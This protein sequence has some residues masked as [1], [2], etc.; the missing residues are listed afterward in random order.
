MKG[1]TNGEGLATLDFEIPANAKL[2]DDGELTIKGEKNG[3]TREADEDLDISAESFVYL[4]LDKPIYQPNQKLFARGLYLNPLKRPLSDENLEFEITDEN[5]ETVYEQTAKTSRFGAAHIEWQIPANLKLGKYKLEV[6]NGNDDVIGASEF[7]I[8][9]YD[10]PNFSVAAKPDKT[11]YLPGQNTAEIVVSANYLFG[12]SVAAGK[13]RIV[14]ETERIWN[15]DEQKYETEEAQTYEGKLNADGNFVARIDLT[16]AHKKLANDD[17]K[18]FEDLHFAAY[19]TDAGTNRTE[20]KRFDIRISK[21]AIHIYFLRYFEDVNPKL[22]FQFYVSTFYADGTPARCNFTVKGNYEELKDEKIFAEAKTNIF[23]AGKSEIRFPEKPFPEAKDRFFLQIAANDKKGNSGNFADNIDLDEKAEQI[24]VKTDKTIYLPNENIEANIIST[25]TDKPVFVDVVRNSSVVYSKR[26]KLGDGRATLQIPFRA[27]FKGILTIAA[28]FHSEDENDLVKFSKT[29]IFPSPDNLKFSVKSLKTVYR[30]NEE[31]NISFNVSSYD[32]KK[33]ETALG[34][35]ILDSAIEERA[36]VEQLPDN[37]KDLRRLLGTADSFGNLTLKDL[38]NFDVSKPID[39]NLQLAAEFLL[40]DKNYEPN[41][42]ESDSYQNNFKEI[43]KD[44]FTEK[45]KIFENVLQT[46]YEKS[47][48]YP[49]DENSLRQILSANG[50]NFDDLR[51]AWGTP[52]K[53]EFR[54]E[55]NF[56]ILSLKTASA[57]KIFGTEDDFTAKEMRFEWFAV[58]RSKLTTIL[59][60]YK[61]QTGKSPQTVAELKTV[62]KQSGIDF[63]ALRDNRNRPLYLIADKYSRSAQKTSAENIGNLDGETQQVM[64]VKTVLQD[65]I[66]FKIRSAG[67]D[68]VIGVYDDFDLGNLTVVMAEKDFDDAPM[69]ATIS[70]SLANGVSGAI[71]GTLFDPVGA[72]I[73]NAE[74]KAENQISA[75]SFSVRTSDEGVYLLA[76]LPSGKYKISA[77]SLGFQQTAIQNVV[78]SSMNLIKLDINL[79]VAGVTLTVDV[80]SD[81]ASVVNTTNSSV[82]TTVERQNKSITA[83]LKSAENGQNSTPRVREYFPETLLWSPEIVTDKNGRADLKF[84]LADSL[85]TWKLYAVASN[86]AGEIGLIEKEIQTFQP[87]F[88]ELDPPKI[89]TESDEIALPVPIRNYT[90]KRQDVTVS[91]A[92]NSWSNLLNGATQNVE[93][94]ANNSQNAIFNF[95]ASAPIENG[96]QK[97][98]ALAKNEG[99]AIEKYVTVKPNGKEIVET[100]SK[101]FRGDAAFDVNF[102]VNS[103]PNTRRAEIKIYPNM[104]AHVAESVEGLLQRPHGCGEQ[105][106]SSTYP[107]LMIL[108]IE[109]D[110]GK[111]V[112]ANTKTQ[113]E[114]YL[115]E[116]YERLL[117]YQTPSGGFS[118]WGKN[119]TP[120]VALTAYILRFL[121]DAKDFIAVD[122]KVIE[123]ARRLAFQTTGN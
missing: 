66:L 7:K 105:T 32:G 15:Y 21:E 33:T 19:F 82:K 45:L 30:P 70:K 79:Q 93:I 87:F 55:R 38:N 18:R 46:N 53:I 114:T 47:G 68:G 20:Q 54:S 109:K 34:V 72:V 57:D 119:D 58:T 89:L 106:T 80:V 123:N 100:Q 115:R 61:Q 74:V 110:L 103:F 23:G 29:I 42:F 97:I 71:T 17:W 12:K 1:R 10:L 59:N 107:N 91:M 8:T 108:K 41:F 84:K 40:A 102:P 83:A 2:D 95:R 28:Y 35:V 36:A 120:N 49:N 69:L 121:N 56:T 94:A 22:P 16:E 64:R 26:I 99:D 67:A 118:Y 11:Y 81:V 101:I 3:V 6:K 63:D 104:F 39:E 43:F 65:G 85:T 117:N 48:E 92:E 111:S 52:F 78:V 5:D 27:D 60:N 31:A 44:Y 50:V 73:P 113:A 98:T 25:E 14:R 4:N 24:R 13:A 9:R 75:E 77:N 76:N 51:D 86:E 112:D 96:R 88:A 116:G 122:E 37:Y 62:W 90:N